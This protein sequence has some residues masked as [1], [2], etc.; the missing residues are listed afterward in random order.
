MKNFVPPIESR[1]D[2]ELIM[3][4]LSDDWDDEAIER[5]KEELNKRNISADT[6]LHRLNELRPGYGS[7][8]E[9]I[10]E[11]GEVLVTVA[12]FWYQ[13]QLL[14]VKS[15]LESEG[16]PCF[17]KDELTIQIQPLLSIP[18]GGIKLQVFESDVDRALNILHESGYLIEPE[19]RDSST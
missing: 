7:D 4:A 17:T 1:S 9:V 10:L 13:H 12:T 5:A 2:D 8:A 3:I 15:M 11:R 18:L 16:I 6:Q 19:Q 14:L